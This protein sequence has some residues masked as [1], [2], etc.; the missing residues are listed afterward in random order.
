VRVPKDRVVHII[1]YNDSGT[2]HSRPQMS[3]LMRQRC[4]EKQ[5]ATLESQFDLGDQD[6][7]SD[8]PCEND[9]SYTIECGLGRSHQV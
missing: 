7:L 2:T 6:R 5:I 8:I 1:T 4:F 3:C 9:I